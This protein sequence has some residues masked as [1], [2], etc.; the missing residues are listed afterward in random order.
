MER[1]IPRGTMTAMIILAVT[2]GSVFWTWSILR[3]TNEYSALPP[4]DWM[5]LVPS[6]II[7]FAITG[8]LLFR[9]FD[10]RG[11]LRA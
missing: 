9:S 6:G 11:R 4:G 8:F 3:W 1:T 7:V 10:R 2:V 5:W